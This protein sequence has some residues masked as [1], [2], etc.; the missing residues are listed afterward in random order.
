MSLKFMAGSLNTKRL[1]SPHTT[2]DEHENQIFRRLLKPDDSYNIE[3][4]YWADLP[5]M[6]RASFVALT[7]AQEVREELGAI[8][9][10]IQK[11]PLSPV[12]WYLRKAV[13]PG[14]GLGFEG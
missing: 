3:G 1:C 10:M 8:G 14:A 2:G 4:V 11:S 6:K 9:S 5:Y 13:L 7:D 12:G